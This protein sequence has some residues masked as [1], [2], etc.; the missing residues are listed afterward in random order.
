MVNWFCCIKQQV[1]HKGFLHWNIPYNGSRHMCG[2][3]LMGRGFSLLGAILFM[4][5][6]FLYV[7]LGILGNKVFRCKSSNSVGQCFFK[8]DSIFCGHSGI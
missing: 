6:A 3:D 1:L 7:T 5:G 8:I 4:L 2:I